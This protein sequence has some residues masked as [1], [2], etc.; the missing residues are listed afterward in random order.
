M[1]GAHLV[2]HEPINSA[3]GVALG[4][5]GY[6]FRTTDLDQVH[7]LAGYILELDEGGEASR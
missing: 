6:L 5:H 4:D 1:L 2:H 3:F 7:E